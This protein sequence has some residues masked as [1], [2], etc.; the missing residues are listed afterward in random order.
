[1]VSHVCHA[2]SGLNYFC[3]WSQGVA[4]GWYVTA[5]QAS[6]ILAT[7]SQGVA[8]GWY[9]TALQASKPLRLP[10]DLKCSELSQIELFFVSPSKRA[11]LG[12]SPNSL[13]EPFECRSMPSAF[14]ITPSPDNCQLIT[15]AMPLQSAAGSTI[16]GLPEKPLISRS[17]R[18][19]APAWECS[20]GRSSVPS[21]QDPGSIPIS[22]GSPR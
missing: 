15:A 1:M 19:H 4:L 3:P 18:S 9:V 12:P 22:P 10:L 21:P 14:K 5:L 16:R 17:D 20:P 11:K 8:L 2:L 6:T 13:K 7:C